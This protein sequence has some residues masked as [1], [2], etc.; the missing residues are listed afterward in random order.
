[1]ARIALSFRWWNMCLHPF[2]INSD[3]TVLGSDSSRLSQVL[4]AWVY[5]KDVRYMSK[6]NPA[7]KDNILQRITKLSPQISKAGKWSGLVQGQKR[8][9]NWS[10][11]R[12]R[13]FV[14]FVCLKLWSLH[15]EQ[16]L[17]HSG[18]SVIFVEWEKKNFF[19]YVN[20]DLLM[21][22]IMWLSGIIFIHSKNTKDNNL[23]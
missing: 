14:L 10:S 9:L 20:E 2:Q 4:F 13:I 3:G 22:W 17:S 8:Y 5:W 7:V 23:W 12:T 6:R 21:Q 15:H 16:F 19:Q 18:P 11:K 1:M